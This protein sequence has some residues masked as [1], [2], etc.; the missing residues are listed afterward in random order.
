MYWLGV[1]GYLAVRRWHNVG[2][3]S[4]IG[5]VEAQLAMGLL[6]YPF[7]PVC[8]PS[9]PSLHSVS[10]SGTQWLAYTSHFLQWK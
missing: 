9:P 8:T 10:H 2:C 3:L 6:E 1:A 4:M 5:V 7:V